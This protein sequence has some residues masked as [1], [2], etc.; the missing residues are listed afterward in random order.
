MNYERVTLC[1]TR[2]TFR[3]TTRDLGAGIGLGLGQ[4][5][6]DSPSGGYSLPGSAEWRR[7]GDA[8]RSYLRDRGRARTGEGRGRRR[9]ARERP[10]PRV[11]LAPRDRRPTF[12]EARLSRG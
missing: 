7:R 10:C 1:C 11:R 4:S 6:T 9:V 3:T 5:A 8:A 12:R 2:T